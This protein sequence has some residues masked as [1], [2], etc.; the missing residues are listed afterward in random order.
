MDK[1]VKQRAELISIAIGLYSEGK[2]YDAVINELRNHVDTNDFSKDI[3]LDAVQYLAKG[4]LEKENDEDKGVQRLEEIYDGLIEITKNKEK[5]EKA[6][7]K[8]EEKKLY[9]F[10]VIRTATVEFEFV[11][12][13][14]DRF[15][16]EQIVEERSGLDDYSDSVGATYDE[17]NYSHDKEGNHPYI[18][19][20]YTSSS[21]WTDDYMIERENSDE[22]T[23]YKLEE[24]EWSDSDN[25]YISKDDLLEDKGLLDNEEENDDNDDDE[26]DDE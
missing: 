2:D 13:A 3:N 16:A 10:R 14:E 9:E 7:V 23:I 11:V 26:D 24:D 21:W 22:Y 6:E 5:M 20:V 4:Y 25:V 1:M 19:R 17:S 12:T 18:E 15:E 8:I